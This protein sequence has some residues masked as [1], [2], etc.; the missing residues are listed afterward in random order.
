MRL[1]RGRLCQPLLAYLRLNA[2]I[3]CDA[4]DAGALVFNAFPLMPAYIGILE[5]LRNDLF[6]DLNLEEERKLADLGKGGREYFVRLYRLSNWEILDA[7]ISL[8]RVLQGIL[9]RV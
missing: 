3:F 6:G 2:G 1:K 8:A 5:G 4:E 7:A 9:E